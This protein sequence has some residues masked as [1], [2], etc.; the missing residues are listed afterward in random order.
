MKRLTKTLLC[1]AI[2]VTIGTGSVFASGK[3]RMPEAPKSRPG[4]EKGPEMPKS[5]NRFEKRPDM[6]PGKNGFK[7]HPGMD[8]NR[9]G[10]FKDALIGQVSSVDE[11][12]GTMKIADAD[13]KETTVII[14]PFT[15]IFVA[16]N[17]KEAPKGEKTV[18][19][20]KKGDW[21]LYSVFKTETEKK[22]AARVFVKNK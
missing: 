13:G 6:K 14:C 1:A 16:D 19:D 10:P 9:K 15:K 7:M 22:V 3:S 8:R 2:A 18:S 17:S 4:F 5:E 12:N 11:K 21:V 20:I